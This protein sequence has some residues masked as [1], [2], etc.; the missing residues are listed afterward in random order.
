MAFGSLD[1]TLK[2]IDLET[3]KVIDDY[4]FD[5]EVTS[6]EYIKDTNGEKIIFSVNVI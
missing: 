4:D 6:L 1:N 3:K 2:I 5:G